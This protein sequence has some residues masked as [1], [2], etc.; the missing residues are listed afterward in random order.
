MSPLVSPGYVLTLPPTSGHFCHRLGWC[1]ACSGHEGAADSQGSRGRGQRTGGLSVR[2]CPQIH[3]GPSYGRKTSLTSKL[4]WALW[5]GR[6]ELLRSRKTPGR[7]A[8][9]AQQNRSFCQTCDPGQVAHCLWGPKSSLLG[10][11][12]PCN[13]RQPQGSTAG[14]PSG[15]GGW[16]R[17]L[18][19]PWEDEP[20]AVPG[21]QHC[22]ASSSRSLATWEASGSEGIAGSRR[23]F[24]F[25]GEWTPRPHR[26]SEHSITELHLSSPVLI[27]R[28]ALTKLPR[29]NW[30]L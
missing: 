16:A 17:R 18:Q 12:L 30:T 26:L 14:W 3:L 13:P 9:R 19:A 4:H 20:W 11:C 23:L 6:H 2:G 15:A 7:E 27:L 22:P 24:M 28:Q 1:L 29:L 21:L 5:P 8:F 25:F 10:W